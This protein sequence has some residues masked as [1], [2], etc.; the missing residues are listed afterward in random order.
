MKTIC[1]SFV[2]YSFMTQSVIIIMSLHMAL[3][4][5]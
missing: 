1:N 3:A 5:R 2:E 4:F